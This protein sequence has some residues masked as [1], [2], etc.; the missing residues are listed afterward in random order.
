MNV[1]FSTAPEDR[2]P[3]AA[4]LPFVLITFFITWGIIGVYVFQADIATAWFGEISGNHPA[5]FLATWAPAIAAFIVVLRHCGVA[6]LKAFLS[7]VTL[8]RCSTSWAVFLLFG[9]PFTFIAGAWVKGTPA[10]EL[11]AFESVEA[12]VGALV[13]MLFLG[14]IE[15][16]GWRG[17][18]QPILQRHMAPLWAGLLIGTTWGL[19]HLPAFFLSGTVYSGW[20]FAPFFVGNVSLAVIVTPLF[21]TTRGSIMLPAIFHYQLINPLWPDAQPYDTYFFVLIA[22]AIVWLNRHTMCRRTSAV[23]AVIPTSREN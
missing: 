17:L 7:R 13:L 21:N 2:L 5:Y 9:I 22:A 18:A 10:S 15:E 1:V 6:G 8:W 3:S 12:T 23:I 14:P 4:L 20:G 19:W 16:F 11:I